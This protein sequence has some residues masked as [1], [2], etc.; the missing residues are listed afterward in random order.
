MESITIENTFISSM[1]RAIK[2]KGCFE[3]YDDVIISLIREHMNNLDAVPHN[4]VIDEYS[5]H[6]SGY[7]NE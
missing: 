1:L 7:S 4:N 5:T 6:A 3:S 2:N